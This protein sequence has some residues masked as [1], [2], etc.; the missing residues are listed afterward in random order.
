MIAGHENRMDGCRY[1][2]QVNIG[3]NFS[4]SK[5]VEAITNFSNRFTMYSCDI[6]FRGG[7]LSG[8]SIFIL[9]PP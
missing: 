2:L 9:L 6:S 5:L 8:V 4:E 7:E 1:V 3:K